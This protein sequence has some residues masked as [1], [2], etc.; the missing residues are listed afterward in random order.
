MVNALFEPILHCVSRY[1]ATRLVIYYGN[2][3]VGLAM[4][5]IPRCTERISNLLRIKSISLDAVIVYEMVPFAAYRAANKL[6]MLFHG[7]D[8]QRNLPLSVQEGDWVRLPSNRPTWFLGRTPVSSHT[9]SWSVQPF[10]HGSRT[11]PTKGQ[12][13][14][15]T[16]RQTKTHMYHKRTHQEMRKSEREL[17]YDSIAHVLQNTK[18]ENLLR[19]TN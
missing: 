4:G 19:L 9:E 10:L 11:W 14:R 2:S 7:L 12:R 6:L 1:T 8:N 16:D 3:S 13:H 5:R 17:F 18:K 15:Q